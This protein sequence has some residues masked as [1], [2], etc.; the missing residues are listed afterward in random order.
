VQSELLRSQRTTDGFVLWR[1]GAIG[2]SGLEVEAL[3][4]DI[5]V[6]GVGCQTDGQAA[7]Y[8]ANLKEA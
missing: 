8:E 4:N 3:T 6:H 2:L 5:F 7:K 1:G